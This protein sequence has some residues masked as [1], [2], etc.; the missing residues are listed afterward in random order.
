MTVVDCSSQNKNV[1]A[2]QAMFKNISPI[3]TQLPAPR[4]TAI[5][6]TEEDFDWNFPLRDTSYST[7]HLHSLINT[8]S[9]FAAYGLV[10]S[11]LL[12]YPVLID[13]DVIRI[14]RRQVEKGRCDVGVQLH[15][16]VT[17]PLEPT[18]GTDRRASFLTNLRPEVESEKLETCIRQFKN[19]FGFSPEI[20]RA[21]RYGLSER[22]TTFLEENGFRIDTSVAPRT[23][24]A[25]ESGPDY[26]H[27]DCDI[28]W[29]GKSR[30]LLELPLC[31]SIIGWAGKHSA[32]IYRG[33]TQLGPAWVHAGALLARMRCAERATLS[34]EGN[35]VL[36]MKRLVKALRARGNNI[37]TLSFHSSSLQAGRNP[38]VKSKADLHDL[39]DR[40]SAILEYLVDVCNMSVT[41]ARDLPTIIENAE[42]GVAVSRFG[43]TQ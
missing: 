24:W 14:I 29:F 27:Y 5:I 7:S 20:F 31:R 30:R 17:P 39:L 4:L 43:Q 32:S 13:R 8:E 3:V 1:D 26:T 41:K 28:F 25:T 10:P 23:S 42:R 35:D 22:T 40:L 38:Y 34:P 12:T 16:W 11:Y 18:G 19:C 33:S 15:P 21:G 36:A 9:T 37:F 2:S 6:D